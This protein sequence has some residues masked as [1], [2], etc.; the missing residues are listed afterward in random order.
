[1]Y[2]VDIFYGDQ[3]VEISPMFNVKDFLDDL[4]S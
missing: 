1:M 2:L 4:P 3:T